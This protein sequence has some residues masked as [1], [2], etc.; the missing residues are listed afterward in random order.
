MSDIPNIAPFNRDA[1]ARGGYL[2]TT[3]MSVGSQFATQ[4]TTDTILQLGNFAGRRLL[5]MGCGDGFYTFRLWDQGHPK[6]ITGVD[7]A[8]KAIDVANQQ[9]EARPIHFEVGNAHHLPFPD[10]SFDL[11]LIQSIL[12]HD[13]DPPAS[14]REALRLA[15]EILIHEPN[16]S[17]LGLKV[18]EKLS[19][20]HREHGERSYS[21]AQVSHWIEQAGGRVTNARYAGFVP[22]FSPAWLAKP[23]K[24]IEPLIEAVPVLK[25]IGCAVYVVTAVRR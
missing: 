25:Q 7:M 3:Q 15:P 1:E 9:K 16:G 24:L 10:N 4:R 18:I 6:A 22:M 12:H 8:D 14:I 23:A 11:A 13:D 20:Y 19:P 5:D 21:L 2:Y 17:N